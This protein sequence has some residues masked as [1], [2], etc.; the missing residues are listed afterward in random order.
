MSEKKK[1]KK[2]GLIFD[3]ILLAYALCFML[4]LFAPFSTYLAAH[5]SYWFSF[6]QMFP[7]VMVAHVSLLV[8]AIVVVIFLSMTKIQN[9]LYAI[10]VGI[11]FLLYIQGNYI[12]RK[13][14]VLNGDTIDWNSY[15]GYACASIILFVI[16]IILVILLVTKM[17][18]MLFPIGRYFCIFLIAIQ[19]ITLAVLYLQAGT[20]EENTKIITDEGLLEYSEEGNVV[21]FVL[22]TFDSSYMQNILNK[23]TEYRELFKDFTYYPNTVGAY[24][25]TKCSLPFILT[26]EW[27]ENDQE[28][29]EYIK[30]AYKDNKLYE[31]LEENGYS[32]EIYAADPAFVNAE[33]CPAMNVR[34]G[35]YVLKDWLE[36]LKAEYKLSLFQYMPHQ[37]KKYFTVETEEFESLRDIQA[38]EEDMNAYTW[39]IQRF[40][41]LLCNTGLGVNRTQKTFKV[42]HLDGVHPS[43]SFGK[44]LKSDENQK[45][46]VYD[47]V[48]G[49]FTFLQLYF[50]RLREAG[51]Y[52]DTTIIIMADHGYI[53]YNQNSLFM[54]KNA[55][56]R[57]ELQISQA[58]MSYEYFRDFLINVFKGASSDEA[59]ITKCNLVSKQRRFLHYSWNDTWGNDLIDGKYMPTMQEI[60]I[61]GEAW[62]QDSMIFTGNYYVPLRSE[63]YTYELG[64]TLYFAK[65]NSTANDYCIYGFGE[66]EEPGTWTNGNYSLMHFSL[67]EIETDIALKMDYGTFAFDHE[68]VLYA[69]GNLIANFIANDER[70]KTIIIP[71][72]YVADGE[73]FLKFYLPSAIS[74]KDIGSSAAT[75]KLAL[76]MESITLFSTEEKFSKEKQIKGYYEI[77]QN[78]Q[79]N[80]EQITR[81][82]ASGFGTI[83]STGMWTNG[84]EACL[85][86]FLLEEYEN[87]VM[88]IEFDTFAKEQSVMLYMNDYLVDEFTVLGNQLYEIEIPDYVIQDE[89]F[90]VKFVLPTAISPSEINVG[91]SDTKLALFMKNIC[92]FSR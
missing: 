36:F 67:G 30:D 33:D 91:D 69:N 35:H 42:Y 54:V 84:E 31:V 71:K 76:F 12:P 82:I 47:E 6:A 18:K 90:N 15:R 92:I 50:E 88:Q 72:E 73:L 48:E 89:L 65:S 45:Y 1:N 52:E 5:D 19:Y 14:G 27:Y 44:D 32:V 53:N 46:D 51:I 37:L 13:Y 86:F 39:S 40:Y 57:H 10:F 38:N 8:L 11:L 20:Q 66:N 16:S 3:W 29:G 7:I 26:G 4:T 58:P 41:S 43:Y 21:V 68:V 63:N 59:F 61:D 74:P 78:V 81:Y 87:L 85:A 55:N 28:Y 80:T 24:S 79:F 22:D 62:T 75:M 83:E 49:N 2:T 25:T 77:G 64:K 17:K 23:N 70:T 56:E 34:E 9:Y 60:Y